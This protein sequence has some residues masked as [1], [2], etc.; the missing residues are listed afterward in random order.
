MNDNYQEHHYKHFQVTFPYN[1]SNDFN[2]ESFTSV[3]RGKQ[4]YSTD[5]HFRSTT[6]NSET[7]STDDPGHIVDDVDITS[8]DILSGKGKGPAAA[9]GNK[10]FSKLIRQYKYEY[11]NQINNK[12]KRRIAQR[13]LDNIKNQEPPGRFVKSTGGKI[14]AWVVQDD[15][16][17][18]S[19]I[20]Q[21]LREKRIKTPRFI[22]INVMMGERSKPKEEIK[23]NRCNTEIEIFSLLS[24]S[25]NV[26][27]FGNWMLTN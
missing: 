26:S 11:Q 21:A 15:S 2:L 3:T 13:V 12:L 8:S 24:H 4:E 16:F 22:P 23:G 14:K 20:S 18:M 25:S 9:L 1:G 6:I 7:F 5:I 19:K 10:F 27:N 17:A